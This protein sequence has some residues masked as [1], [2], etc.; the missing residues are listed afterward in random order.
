MTTTS[1]STNNGTQVIRLPAELRL[2]DGVKR[3]SIRARG[4][5]RIIAPIGQTWD[6]FFL[7]DVQVAADFMQERPNQ[8]QPDREAL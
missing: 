5:E 3:V 7:D 2:P 1:V 4:V 6:S 8:T